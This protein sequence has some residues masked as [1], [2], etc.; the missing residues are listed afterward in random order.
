MIFCSFSCA[1][2]FFSLEN[3]SYE[4][5]TRGRQVY[6]GGFASELEA[7]LGSRGEGARAL[8]FR[9]G[10]AD[11]VPKSI[12]YRLLEPAL[13]I[14]EPV[15]LICHEGNFRDLLGCFSLRKAFASIC[16][17]RS[18]VTLNCWPTSSSAQ[19]T[20]VSR[21]RPLPPSGERSKAVM[22]MVTPRPCPSCV[23]R[24]CP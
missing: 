6:L 23:Y 2:L 16:R 3:K 11:A 18:R 1:H 10:I 15:R 19:R 9:V 14:A 21:A 8:D 7:A 12:A 24:A 20:R 5:S 22:T 4:N 13:G 17:I